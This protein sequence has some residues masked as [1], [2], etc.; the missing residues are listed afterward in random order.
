LDG[1]SIRPPVVNAIL[2]SV[3]DSGEKPAP[4]LRLAATL[5]ENYVLGKLQNSKISF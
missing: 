4:F 2:L 3:Y 5:P 1:D